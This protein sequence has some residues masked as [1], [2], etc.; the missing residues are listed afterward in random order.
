MRTLEGENARKTSTGG[1][2]LKFDAHKVNIHTN[3]M[4]V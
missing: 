3:E 1:F 2:S 4:I